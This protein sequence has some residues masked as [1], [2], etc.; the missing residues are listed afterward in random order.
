MKAASNTNDIATARRCKGRHALPV[1]WLGVAVLFSA[2]GGDKFEA[3]QTYP[4]A[5]QSIIIEAAGRPADDGATP[6][7]V[8]RVSEL[9]DIVVYESSIANDGEDLTL[10]NVRPDLRTVNDL[11]LCLNGS[12]QEDVYVRMDVVARISSATARK[13]TE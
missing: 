11:R 1:S 4:A 8:R 7:R 2:C 3:L 6:V 13:C 10:D 5:G 12:A 9:E